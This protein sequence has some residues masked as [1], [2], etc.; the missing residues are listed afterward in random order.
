MNFAG[1]IFYYYVET[2][3]LPKTGPG[4]IGVIFASK[5]QRKMKT[6]NSFLRRLYFD[7]VALM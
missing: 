3:I 7:D 4:Q 6:S 5:L 1:N 2:E